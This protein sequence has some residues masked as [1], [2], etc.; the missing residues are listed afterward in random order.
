[1]RARATALGRNCMAGDVRAMRRLI[2]LGAFVIMLVV[3]GCASVTQGIVSSFFK[4]DDV[5]DA[6]CRIT[7]L[8]AV[9]LPQKLDDQETARQAGQSYRKL[10]IL[11]VHGIGRHDEGY[12]DAF[13]EKLLPALG[14]DVRDGTIKHFNLSSA[15]AP[16]QPLGT[17]RASRHFNKTETRELIVYELTWSPIA[18]R[19]KQML[20]YDFSDLY[21]ARRAELN[22][23]AKQF[24]ND[25]LSDV[26]LYAG[27][28][29]ESI[30]SSVRQ[31]F[32]WMTTGD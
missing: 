32:C 31:A 3:P 5:G 29:R 24:I 14:L 27:N 20:V 6:E 13:L 4:I 11:I 1:M 16:G 22:S 30:L 21:S 19:E 26:M 25:N 9:G 23:T 15:A 18:E 10:K 7:G 17:L 2:F 12:S 28:T 8:T